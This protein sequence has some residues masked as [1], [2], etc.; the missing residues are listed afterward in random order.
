LTRS[1]SLETL[2]RLGWRTSLQSILE[3]IIIHRIATPS[4]ISDPS[5]RSSSTSARTPDIHSSLNLHKIPLSSIQ[6]LHT[7]KKGISP[8]K[9]IRFKVALPSKWWESGH[10]KE[11]AR[12]LT[13]P[14]ACEQA[15]GCG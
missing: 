8:G 13:R 11:K 3:T 9:T 7:S 10:R 1:S 5:F 4:K 14:S 6:I 2:A 15:G 12:E